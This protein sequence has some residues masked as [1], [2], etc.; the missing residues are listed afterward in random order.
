MSDKKDWVKYQ[1]TEEDLKEYLGATDED[2][3][4]TVAFKWGRKR[5]SNEKELFVS[6][7]GS[8]FAGFDFLV[9]LSKEPVVQEGKNKDSGEINHE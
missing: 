5:Y 3:S 7:D 4:P 9:D 2:V 6:I 8:A 1:G